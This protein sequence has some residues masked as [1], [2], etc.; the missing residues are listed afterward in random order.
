MISFPLLVSPK[1]PPLPSQSNKMADQM[2][3]AYSDVKL[4]P[5][6]D[7][8]SRDQLVSTFWGTDFDGDTGVCRGSL[9]RAI[10]LAS[11][12]FADLQIGPL[13]GRATPDCLWVLSVAFSVQ[14]EVDE[15]D[16]C[17]FPELRWEKGVGYSSAQ[18]PLCR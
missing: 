9:T 2:Y 4:I 1:R 18:R 5:N 16:G 13:F 12:N 17:S 3:A 14:A 10:P 6:K 8:A 7:K 11:L 15:C